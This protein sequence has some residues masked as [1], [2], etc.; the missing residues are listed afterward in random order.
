M[1]FLPSLRMICISI[2]LLGTFAG[3]QI[4][5]KSSTQ[6]KKNRNSTKS[7]QQEIN[8]S[9]TLYFGDMRFRFQLPSGESDAKPIFGHSDRKDFFE[10]NGVRVYRDRNRFKV[11]S[12]MFRWD[13]DSIIWIHSPPTDSNPFRRSQGNAD[14][15]FFGDGGD[16][17]VEEQGPEGSFVWTF[18]NARVVLS[19]DSPLTYHFRGNQTRMPGSIHLIL[20]PQGELLE[21]QSR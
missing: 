11:G 3:C 15:T 19:T 17:V 1:R 14:L 8:W 2:F 12:S 5:D 6:Q 4:V 16:P 7:Q 13:S 10:V 21:K 9:P 20:G 18:K